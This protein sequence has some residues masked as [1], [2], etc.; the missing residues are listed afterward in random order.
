MKLTEDM[1]LH[2]EHA[3]YQFTDRPHNAFQ[4]ENCGAVGMVKAAQALID[5]KTVVFAICKPDGLDWNIKEII[6]MAVPD[7]LRVVRYLGEGGPMGASSH[8]V[9]GSGSVDTKGEFGYDD[10]PLLTACVCM[11]VIRS[12]MMAI[13]VREDV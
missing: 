9:H 10:L 1:P 5:G 6:R 2:N 13:R 4:A 7:G 8:T 12:G 11:A 3:L